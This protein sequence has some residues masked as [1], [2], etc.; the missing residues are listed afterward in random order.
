MNVKYKARSIDFFT[1]IELLVVIAVISILSALLLP[2]LNQALESARQSFCRANQKQIG[3]ALAMYSDDNH[4]YLLPYRYTY[5][6]TTK[7]YGPGLLN[8]AKYLTYKSFICP[9]SIKALYNCTAPSGAV[10]PNVRAAWQTGT[11][12]GLAETSSAWQYSSYGQNSIV[13]DVSVICLKINQIK[14]PAYLIAYAESRDTDP[15]Y[16]IAHSLVRTKPTEYPRAYPWHRGKSLNIMQFDGHV[17]TV[18]AMM[19]GWNG[20][21]ELYGAGRPLAASTQ[22][23]SPWK[24]E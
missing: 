22:I 20:S 10:G 15:A 19:S 24:N 7:A 1:L 3:L 18:V 14:R 2:A 6:G 23:N 16:G 11:I 9:V 13:F 8:K 12:G 21:A 4:G 5:S 17:I